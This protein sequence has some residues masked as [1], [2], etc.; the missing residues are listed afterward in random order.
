MRKVIAAAVKTNDGVI[1]FMP[2]PNRHH[3]TIHALHR[4]NETS[5][6]IIARGEQGF[7][8][9]DGTFAD[10]VTAGLDAIAAGQ[11]AALSHPPN[12]YSEDLW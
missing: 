9:N 10:R 6:L 7:V 3:H 8:M 2:P 5:G 12:L 1:H 4:A 11:I